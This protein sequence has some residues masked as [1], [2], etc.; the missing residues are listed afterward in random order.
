[1][2]LQG[3][4][5]TSNAHAKASGARFTVFPLMCRLLFS[6]QIIPGTLIYTVKLS[7]Y[8]FNKEVFQSVINRLRKHFARYG[9]AEELANN[10]Q[11]TLKHRH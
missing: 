10:R 8:K 2:H 11:R 7:I 4:I 6:R 5:T 3:T 1:M 9:I